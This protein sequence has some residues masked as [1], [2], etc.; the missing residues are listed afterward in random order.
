MD[1]EGTGVQP[2]LLE[3]LRNV[4]VHRQQMEL[5]ERKG[6]GH[7]DTMCDAIMEAISVALCQA[8]IEAVCL[9]VQPDWPAN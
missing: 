9:A 1:R 8:Y 3:D 4:P 5:V 2:M 6:V 7:P